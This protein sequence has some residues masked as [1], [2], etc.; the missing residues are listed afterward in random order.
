MFGIGMP[1]LLLVMALAVVFIGP[2]KL[3]HLAR[4]LGRGMREFRDAT[5][6]LKQSLDLDEA[7][8]IS[9][10]SQNGFQQRGQDRQENKASGDED[11]KAAP[12]TP[13]SDESISKT[14]GASGE[15]AKD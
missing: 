12:S 2:Q 4:T 1:E 13:D 10:G 11:K 6:D 15:E 8:V 7:K 5:D 14:D 3:P 9:P